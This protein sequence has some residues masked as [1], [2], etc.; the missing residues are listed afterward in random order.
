MGTLINGP[1][2]SYVIGIYSN[3]E[4]CLRGLLKLNY[5]SFSIHN[6]HVPRISFPGFHLYFNHIPVYPG[7]D[8]RFSPLTVAGISV[9]KTLKP[10]GMPGTSE[11]PE[12]LL[13]L[14]TN[15][16][17]CEWFQ[18]NSFGWQV[19]HLQSSCFQLCFIYHYFKMFLMLFLV[20]QMK[21][22]MV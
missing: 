13:F 12:V 5:I 1:I 11:F 2:C 8:V 15:K 9:R 22:F 4:C 17:Q 10:S 19:W 21:G 6:Y 14:I 18:F 7:P 3:P 16:K 20:L